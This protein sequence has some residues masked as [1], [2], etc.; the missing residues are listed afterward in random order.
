MFLRQQKVK[1]SQGKPLESVDLQV[2]EEIPTSRCSGNTEI[3]AATQSNIDLKKNMAYV[4][5]TTI[6]LTPNTA[7]CTHITK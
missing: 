1:G 5:P 2:Y 3:V 4:T 7:Y 6:H